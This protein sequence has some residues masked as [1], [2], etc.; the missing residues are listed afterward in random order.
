MDLWIDFNAFYDGRS[1]RMVIWGQNS[2]RQEFLF[3]FLGV[4]ERKKSQN[5]SKKIEKNY[6][7]ASDEID[8]NG[9]LESHVWIFGPLSFS[10]MREKN[11][12]LWKSHSLI[13]DVIRCISRDGVSGSATQ[14][15]FFFNLLV[16][17]VNNFSSFAWKFSY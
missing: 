14:N 8:T 10:V 12:F 4:F 9:P 1:Q 6:F 2:P 15:W 13:F 16:F 11:L 17:F 7:Y 5:P 3:N